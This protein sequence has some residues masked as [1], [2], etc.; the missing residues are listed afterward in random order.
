MAPDAIAL[1]LLAAGR[2]ERFGGNKLA[3]TL[4]GRPVIEHTMAALAPLPLRWRFA[5]VSATTPPLPGYHTLP[6]DPPDSPQSASLRLGVAAAQAR[7]AKAVLVALADMP[8]VPTAHF[9]TLLDRFDGTRIAS[10]AGG[11]PMP[12]AL[13][14]ASCFRALQSLT[15]DRGAGLLLRDAPAVPLP[16][17]ADLDIDTPQ[18]LVLAAQA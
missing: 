15:G 6:L 16:K 8:L 2:S 17:G 7:G 9:A 4:S 18:D 5:V 14:G 10:Q 13:F 12:P 1:V 11:V 3:A